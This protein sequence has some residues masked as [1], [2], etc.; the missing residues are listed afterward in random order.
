MEYGLNIYFEYFFTSK[1]A[2]GGLASRLGLKMCYFEYLM[3]DD[4]GRYHRCD[5]AWTARMG[6]NGLTNASTEYTEGLIFFFCIKIDI[7]Y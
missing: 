2:L 3:G 1:A 7:L 5:V 4:R 6:S